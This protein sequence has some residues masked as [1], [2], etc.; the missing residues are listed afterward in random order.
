MMLGQVQQLEV[1]EGW[2]RWAALVEE[3]GIEWVGAPG[4]EPMAALE[5]WAEVAWVI[6]SEV[7]W[8]PAV[9]GEDP[10]AD[11]LV[12]SGVRALVLQGDYQMWDE[13]LQDAPLLWVWGLQDE[14]EAEVWLE[15]EH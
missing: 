6:S 11:Q 14:K 10:E 12:C 4:L 8:D 5:R 3:A 1:P 15:E 9:S 2:E 7:S 13:G